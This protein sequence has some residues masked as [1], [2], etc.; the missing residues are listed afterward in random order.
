LGVQRYRCHFEPSDRAGNPVEGKATHYCVVAKD[1]EVTLYRAG[2]RSTH[3][4]N[5]EGER[6]VNV[7]LDQ[8]FPQWRDLTAYWD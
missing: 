2:V 7:W 5:S 4:F 1:S 8:R 6:A 3:V